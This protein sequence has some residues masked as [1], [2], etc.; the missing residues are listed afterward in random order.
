MA[1]ISSFIVVASILFLLLNISLVS[2]HEAEKNFTETKQLLESKIDCK[3]LTEDQL[4]KIGEY[5]M[6]QMHPGEAHEQMHKMM[7]LEEGTPAEEQ[8]HIN[9]AKNMYCH[10]PVNDTMMNMMSGMAMDHNMTGMMN[11]NSPQTDNIVSSILFNVLI[12]ALI[13]LVV[14]GIVKISKD[15]L[16]KR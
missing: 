9:M 7:G 15:V 5:L 12:I 3:N 10:E 4:E 2:A 1:K 6:E 16:W 13:V 11:H 14:I 8:M